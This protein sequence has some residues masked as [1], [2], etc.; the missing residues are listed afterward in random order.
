MK[1]RVVSSKEEI[2]SLGT[3]EEMVHLAFRPSNTDILTL[4]TKCPNVKALH[5]PTSYKRTISKST[6]MF[7]DMKGIALIEGDVWGHRK[8]IN[9]YSEVSDT[10]YESI[11][12]YRKDGL[13]DDEIG[14]KMEREL[15][16]STDLL[17]FL[18]KNRK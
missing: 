4:V 17:K 15:H 13:S 10:V 16:M 8:D 11:D 6:Q 18:L 5:I 3:N 2:E 1:I 7:L 12:Q 14:A 9:D